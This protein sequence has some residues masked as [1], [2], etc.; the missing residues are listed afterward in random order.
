MKNTLKFFMLILFSLF[1]NGLLSQEN[2]TKKLSYS[3]SYISPYLLSS[4][5]EFEFVPIF[6]NFEANIHY[7]PFDYI[8]FTSGFGFWVIREIYPDITSSS[9]ESTRTNK[10]TGSMLRVPMQFNFHLIENPLKTDSYLKAVYN[11]A[12]IIEKVVEYENDERLGE[13]LNSGYY[14]SLG[15]GLGTVFLKHKPIGILLEGTI[16]KYLRF[17]DFK[18]STWYSIKIGVVI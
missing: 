18:N 14:P 12:F 15:I 7:K 16:E 13:N 17:G 2:D 3:F 10:V 9:S 6:T 1:S 5:G 8:S 11:N 4:E